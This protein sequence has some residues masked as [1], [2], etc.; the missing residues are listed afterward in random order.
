M[1]TLYIQNKDLTVDKKNTFLTTDISSGTTLTVQS[2]VG[3]AINKIVCIGE[4]GEENSEIVKTHSSTVPTGTT[5]TLLAAL[6]FSHNRGAKVYLINYNQVEVSWSATTTGVKTVL[7]TIDIQSDQDETI[8]NDSVK[9]SGYYFTRF[10]DSINTTYTEYS[11]PVAYAGYGA[12]TVWAIKNRALKDLG[13]KVDGIIITDSWLNEALW[14]GRRELDEDEGVG[15]WSFRIKRNANVDSIIPGTYQMTLPTDLRRPN[16]AENIL[17]I[18]I[19]Q[20]SRPLEYQDIVR[21]NKNYYGIQHTTLDGAVA[22]TDTSISLIDS[23]DFDES[24][25]I[26]VAA[27]SVATIVD[28]ITYT[29]NTEATETLSGV[30]GIQTGGHTTG[31]DVW[32]NASFG[33]PSAFTVNGENKKAEFDLPFN[34]DYAGENVYMDYYATL[35]VYDSDSDVLDEPEYG[36][37]VDFLKWKIKYRKSN[38]NLSPAKDGDY[39]LWEKKKKSFIAKE[40]LGQDIY[41][42][43]D[44]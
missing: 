39:L 4:I 18:R 29:A 2:I 13:E 42:I 22:D 12:N 8:Y 30:T 5:I 24:G 26:S 1:K 7:D 16:T 3:F 40:R 44:I 32:Q 36:L 37:F 21:F 20:D 10:K 23:G 28:S 15:R 14:E 31:R 34:D 27:V 41:I 17:S 11:D 25:T 43:P 9:T 38:G 33:L 19:G 35:P 6:T